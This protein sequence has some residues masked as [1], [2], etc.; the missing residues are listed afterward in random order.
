MQRKEDAKMKKNITLLVVFLALSVVFTA[1]SGGGGGGGGTPNS[2]AFVTSVTGNANLG[3]WAGAGGNTGLAAGNAICQ[4]RANAAG[5]PG[6]FKAWISTS[7]TDAY[8]N[9]HNLTGTKALNCGQAVLPVAAGPWVRTDGTP[10]AP[11]IDNLTTTSHIVY[12][13]L[14]YDEFGHLFPTST[15]NFTNTDWDGEFNSGGGAFTACADWTDGTSAVNLVTGGW[16]YGTLSIWTS[17]WGFPC[18]ST[19]PLIC[20]QTGAGA[21]LPTITA[22]GKKVF[23]TLGAVGS[24]NGNLSTWADAGL[25]TG[26]AAGDA[27]C[28]ARA[29]AAGLANASKFKAWLSDSTH[30]AKD[31]LLSDGPW[32]R[33]DGF[34]IANNKADL[35]DGRLFTSINQDETGDYGNPY[36]WTGTNANGTK[37]TDT[38][39]NWTDGTAGQNGLI[40]SGALVSGSWTN[41]TPIACSGT[42]QLYCFEDQ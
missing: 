42:R 22:T 36:P 8:C 30:E 20:M 32:S 18:N 26:L 39:N 17:G 28:Q 19:L 4:A 15:M 12:T 9:I 25:N 23:V 13:P 10:F 14:N 5:L 21:P 31:R 35:I 3:S 2:K 40:G 38:C 27:I 1:C 16:V 24:G 34:T 29:T 7:T 33:I 41:Y 11:T 37:A 6:T